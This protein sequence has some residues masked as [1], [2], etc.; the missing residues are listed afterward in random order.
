MKD[1]LNAEL[2]R[3]GADKLIHAEMDSNSIIQSGGTP[4]LKP[5][6]WIKNTN[7]I[8]D[9]SPNSYDA[10]MPEQN[11]KGGQCAVNVYEKITDIIK[12]KDIITYDPAF[13]ILQNEVEHAEDLLALA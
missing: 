11:I 5:V 6:D 8:Y 7:C 4:L 2:N 12:D 1:S 10:K 3:H 13:K 9:A